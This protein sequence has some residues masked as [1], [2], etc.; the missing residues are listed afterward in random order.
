MKLTDLC[1]G[2]P[3]AVQEDMVR[4]DGLTA[5]PRWEERTLLQEGLLAISVDGRPA[6]RLVCSP[7][8]LGYLTLGYLISSGR[9]KNPA[10]IRAITVSADGSRAEVETAAPPRASLEDTVPSTGYPPTGLA[11]EQIPPRPPFDWEPRW[12]YTLARAFREGAPLYHETHGIHSCFLMCDGEIRFF[13][14]DI[15]RH[16]ALD[17]ALGRALAEGL[18]LSRCVLFSSGRI[19]ADMMEKVIRA[20]VPML[21]S[22][23]VPTDKAVALARRYRVVL[24]CSARKDAMNIFADRGLWKP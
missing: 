23:A 19:P 12:I 10:D 11:K 5:I 6:A 14:E 13:C 16:N 2:C 22:N 15:G 17:K 21:A 1:T 24:V 18:D 20:G 3:G 4:I 7:R 9:V 8:E